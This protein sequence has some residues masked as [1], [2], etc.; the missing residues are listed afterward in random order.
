MSERSVPILTQLSSV[1]N[2]DVNY[3]HVIIFSWDPNDENPFEI[4]QRNSFSSNEI[5]D[6]WYDSVLS[7]ENRHQ[8]LK[9]SGL[10]GHQY[11]VF[12]KIEKGNFTNCTN[13][14]VS[15]FISKLNSRQYESKTELREK[16][17]K[18]GLPEIAGRKRRHRNSIWH[19][20]RPSLLQ[21]S[22]SI[23]VLS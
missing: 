10:R 17:F 12:C 5:P 15:C 6:D 11:S 2:S 14:V 3:H 1:K 18:Q 19:Y 4:Y 20:G 7:S 8:K 13:Y 21:I 9:L 16:R 22:E 23:F